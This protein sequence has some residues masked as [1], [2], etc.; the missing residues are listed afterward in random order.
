V[1]RANASRTFMPPTAASQKR[2]HTRVPAAATAIRGG[3]TA[4]NRP[5]AVTSEISIDGRH[6][7]FH[8][9]LQVGTAAVHGLSPEQSK[10]GDTN[11]T[12]GELNP[13]YLGFLGP[14]RSRNRRANIVRNIVAD[15]THSDSPRAS[16]SG[17]NPAADAIGGVHNRG[18]TLGDALSHQKDEATDMVNLHAFVG[19]MGLVS[20]RTA[21]V[22]AEKVIERVT[23]AKLRR[24]FRVSPSR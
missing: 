12:E 4:R 8:R 7:R 13:A 16:R 10:A 1:S 14:G 5:T 15:A 20:S 3:S 18:L 17:T 23:E 11:F 21:V 22:A 2:S 6:G 19:R 9:K 24:P